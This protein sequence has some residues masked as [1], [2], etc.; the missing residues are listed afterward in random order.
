MAPR[1]KPGI[2]GK[3]ADTFN[4]L[5]SY[6]ESVSLFL[7]FSVSTCLSQKPPEPLPI[8]RVTLH[9]ELLKQLLGTLPIL[10]VW[11]QMHPS[12]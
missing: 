3:P 2:L 12:R 7:T 4:S 11:A 8:V 6:L 10:P 1:H 5:A 9:P